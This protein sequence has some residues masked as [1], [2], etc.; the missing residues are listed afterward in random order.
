MFNI[1][2]DNIAWVFLA[3]GPVLLLL[4]IQI[5]SIPERGLYLT[6]FATGILI[7]PHLPILRNKFTAVEIIMGLT[8]LALLSRPHEARKS[9]PLTKVQTNALFWGGLFITWTILSF[10]INGIYHPETFI[11]S[12]VETINF[13]YGYLMFVTVILMARDWGRWENCLKGWLWGAVVV[14][15]F[16]VLALSGHGPKWSYDEFSHRICSTLRTDNQVPSFLLPT[17]TVLVFMI[18]ERERKPFEKWFLTALLICVFLTSIGSG[19][20]TA[21]LMLI[22]TIIGILYVAFRDSQYKAFSTKR[23][24]KISFFLFIGFLFYIFLALV[25]YQDDY[26]LGRTPSWQRPVVTLYDWVRGK[27]DLDDNRT[28]QLKFVSENIN[29]NLVLGSGPKNYGEE[30]DVQE[31]HN[32]YAGVLFQMGV[33]GLFLFLTWLFIVVHTGWLASKRIQIPHQRLMVISMVVGMIL[34]L[35]Y[36]MT[37]FGLRQR[38]IWLLAGLLVASDSFIPRRTGQMNQRIGSR[39]L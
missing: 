32:T 5:F 10:S 12:I 21:F 8:W 20:R 26:A 36:S 14:S 33:P 39:E 15:F 31:I 24:V 1:F 2:H 7:T 23:F 35:L 11:G 27:A 3:A 25:N 34:L 19:S 13:V 28:E 6:F 9:P 37:M 4:I 16:G 22:V 38:N 17:F 18:V 30:Y 29:D